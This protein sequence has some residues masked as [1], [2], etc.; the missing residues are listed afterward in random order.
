MKPIWK[1]IIGIV[2]AVLVIL[3]A[4]G[5]YLSRHWQPLLDERLKQAVLVGSDSLYRV[6]YDE[7]DLNLLT[8]NVSLRNFRLTSD[9]TVYEQLKVAQ[10]APDNRFDVSV[11]QLR[12]RRFN[13]GKAL[14]SKQLDIA[15]IR[16][17]TPRINLINEYQYYNDTLAASR[18]E[19]QSHLVLDPFNSIRV[20]KIDLSDIYFKFTK[21]GDS[22]VTENSFENIQ[23]SIQDVLIDSAARRDTS[24]FYYTRSIDLAMGD[25]LFEIPDS[26]YDVG[27]EGLRVRTENRSLELIGLH[28][29]PR[30]SDIEY[31]QAIQQAKDIVKLQFGRLLFRDLNLVSFMRSQRIIAKSLLIDSGS[32]NVSNDMRFPRYPKSKIGRSPHQQLMKLRHPVKLDSVFV[33]GVDISYAE[34]SRKYHKE[35]KITFD[36][37]GGWLANVTND[38]V[39]LRN[40]Q[41]ME[42]DLTAYMMNTGKLHALFSFDML[43]D[44]GSFTYRGTLGPMDGKPLNRILTPLLHVEVASARVKGVSFD[45]RGNDFRNWG[46]FRLDYEDLKVN[47]LRTD[48]DGAT[49]RK[50]LVSFLANEFLINS[51]NPDANGTYHTGTINYRRPHEFSFFKTLWKSLLE[52][53]KQTAG[54]SKERE[55]RLLNTAETVKTVKEKS[56]NF[57]QN[58]FRKRDPKEKEDTPDNND[59]GQ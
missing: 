29:A 13:I 53:I 43:D 5:W 57:F 48:D 31:H 51:S 25:Y 54:I 41:L 42:A 17:D 36:R 45:M 11:A 56:D 32:V 3:I 37:A 4:G 39:F 59:P 20:D 47:L 46:A 49:S 8:G 22:A 10:K 16:I 40:N 38:T 34:V 26:H 50:G 2:A 14:F 55:E 6:D 24:R 35:G 7:I 23:L 21:V 9:S 33:N 30:I 12:I 15:E 52:G 58:L 28:Y 18:D 44:Q 27:F 19:A 1:W